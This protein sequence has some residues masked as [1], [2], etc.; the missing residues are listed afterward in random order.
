MQNG[1]IHVVQKAVIFFTAGMPFKSTV[2]F[3]YASKLPCIVSCLYHAMEKPATSKLFKQM[4]TK[5]ARAKFCE[6]YQLF[7]KL[8]YRQSK[9]SPY[10][11]HWYGRAKNFLLEKWCYYYRTPISFAIKRLH[12]AVTCEKLLRCFDCTSCQILGLVVLCN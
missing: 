10:L 11:T 8:N 1:V 6:E 3:C 9:V 7:A 12:V 2:C 4:S 5:F